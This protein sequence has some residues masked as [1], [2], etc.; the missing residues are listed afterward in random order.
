MQGTEIRVQGLEFR[1]LGFRVWSLGVEG[2]GLRV[3]FFCVCVLLVR[4]LLIGFCGMQYG[5]EASTT[6]GLG[7]NF[8]YFS[9]VLH[10]NP[11]F[12]IPSACFW[13]DSLKGFRV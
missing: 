2:S 9:T 4:G 1:G 6:P 12:R 3:F 13:S 5:A 8:R 10:G 7:T 11:E